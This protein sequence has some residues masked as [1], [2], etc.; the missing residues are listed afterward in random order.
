MAPIENSIDQLQLLHSISSLLTTSLNLKDTLSSIFSLLEDHIHLKKGVLILRDNYTDEYYIEI[1]YGL[2]EKDRRK[3][4]FKVL[5]ILTSKVLESNQV[6]RISE[7]KSGICNVPMDSDEEMP[8][9]GIVCLPIVLG[10]ENIGTLSVFVPQTTVDVNDRLG[11]L[12]TVCLLIA[13][14]IKLKKM[15]EIEKEALRRE[16]V[17]LRDELKDKYNI[18]NMIGNSSSMHQVYESIIQVA[19]SNATVLIRGESGTGKEL[20][21]HAIHYTSPRSTKPFIK[22]NCGAIPE[23]LI[24]SELFGYEKGAFTDAHD[25]KVGKFELA[26]GGTIFLDEIGELAPAVQVK[27][28]R[29]LQEKEIERVGGLKPIKVNVR[30]VTATNRDLESE[31]VSKRF[32]EDLYY[33]LNVFPIFLP[34]L[35]DRKTDVLLLAEHFLDKFSRENEKQ[36]TRISSLAI[37]LLTSYQ[38]PG[39]VRELE[40]CIERAVLVCRTDTIQARDLPPT[41][42]RSD[43]SLSVSEDLTYEEMVNN[44]ERELII[45][46]LKKTRG[47][48]SK[49]ADMLKT[50]QRIIGYKISTL[51]IDYNKYKGRV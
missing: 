34:S 6:E 39:N 13:Q 4:V 50:T 17:L 49:A 40:N 28:L 37:D 5:E 46:A 21:A 36:I 48:K 44:F 9:Y 22:I 2:T 16:N 10:E 43:T 1:G 20:V 31:L 33:R 42:Q 47:N 7:V 12:S 11:L 45:D 29:V 8:G 30:V 27:L 38:W 18:H 14:E 41:L 32:R 3:S 25:T 24:E 19:N 51:Q 15:L 23:S 35:K 26:N